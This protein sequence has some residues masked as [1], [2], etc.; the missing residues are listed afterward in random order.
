MI[1]RALVL[2]TPPAAE[3]L[4]VADVQAQCRIDALEA[5][6]FALVEGYISAAREACENAT[7]RQLIEAAWELRLDR[8]PDSSDSDYVTCG[9]AI[10]LPKP[11]LRELTSIKYLDTSGVETTLSASL[12]QVEP[13]VLQGDQRARV[14][15]AYGTT[16][17]VTRDVPGAVRVR[18]KAGYGTTASS[19]PAPL[20]NGLLLHVAAA[21]ERREDGAAAPGLTA[22]SA[23]WAPYKEWAF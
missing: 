11:P 21:Y 12:Y 6:E 4:T 16:W 14:T 5:S 2:T 3:P 9:E 17:P 10:L 8:F 19:V 7:G 18:F 15:P 23:L 13:P 20:R 22:M 1:Y